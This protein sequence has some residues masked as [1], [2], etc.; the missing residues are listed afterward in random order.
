[1]NSLSDN[2]K[3]QKTIALVAFFLLLLGIGRMF[4]LVTHSPVLGYANSYDMIR[5]QACHQIWPADDGIDI[6]SGTPAAPIHRYALDKK[7]KTPCFPS[8]ELLFTGTAIELAKLKNHITG[9]KLVSIKMIGFVKAFFL[10]ITILIAQ[11]YFLRCNNNIAMATNAISALIVLSDPG[12]TLYFN[13]FYS[14]FSAVYFL[15]LSLIGIVFLAD[16]QCHITRLL[17]LLAG[18]LGLGFSMPQHAPLAFFIGLLLAGYLQ[19]SAKKW[20]GALIILL[21]SALPLTLQ[22]SGFLSSNDKSLDFANKVNFTG[23][24]LSLTQQPDKL[25]NNLQLPDSCKVLAGKNWYNKEVQDKKYCPELSAANHPKISI[26]LLKDPALL[27]T[28]LQNSAPSLKN[29]VFDLYGQVEGEKTGTAI[30]HQASIDNVLRVTPGA[31]FLFMA[32]LPALLSIIVLL[33]G[34]LRSGICYTFL[35]YSLLVFAI[36]VA[37]FFLALSTSG[38]TGLAKNLHLYI[39]LLLPPLVLTPAALYQ[40]IFYTNEPEKN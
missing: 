33:I 16:A 30:Q 8:S 27:V 34:K 37:V 10:A 5:L 2:T 18:L 24:A 3:Y 39:P 15:Y 26:A 36:Q 6:T 40:L 19:F 31:V 25:L 35:L 21:F 28:F 12:V 1:M 20:G 11:L 14:E 13:T 9:E 38:I 17:P 4:S 22:S 29:W 32:L 23:S 7:V